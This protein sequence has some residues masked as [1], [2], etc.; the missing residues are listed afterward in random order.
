MLK[1]KARC[2]NRVYRNG[3]FML[4]DLKKDMDKTKE[5]DP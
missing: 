5:S 4:E 1:K 2:V 3:S